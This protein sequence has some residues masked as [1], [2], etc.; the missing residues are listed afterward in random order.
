MALGVVN[1]G[2]R[3]TRLAALS[4]LLALATPALAGPVCCTT[5]AEKI[6]SRL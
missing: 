5:Y 1:K 4:L 6:L 2:A 3:M